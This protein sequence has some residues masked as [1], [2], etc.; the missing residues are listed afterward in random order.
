[1]LSIFKRKVEGLRELP[2][3]PESVVRIVEQID[4]EGSLASISTIIEQDQVISARVL[5]LV[6]SAFYGVGGRVSSLHHAVQMLGI[7]VLR[8][9]VLSSYFMAID[10]TGIEGLWDHASM[11]SNL[12][13]EMGKKL[14]IPHVEEVTAAALLH[15]I[16]KL[17]LREVLKDQF[18]LCI[19]EL[20]QHPAQ[21]FHQRELDFFPAGHEDAA[22]V[23][24]KRWN[25]PVLIQETAAYHHRPSLAAVY[26]KEVC[27]THLADTIVKTYGYG[28][29]GDYGVE[30]VNKV[31]LKHLALDERLLGKLV[32]E[33]AH[34]L[35]V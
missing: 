25:F 1:M 3:L 4:K 19:K 11:V 27:L 14:D 2:T 30:A 15:D 26:K 23:W 35:I 9:L 8:G 17:I 33:T 20:G 34:I 12:V 24:M 22:L 31:A 21:T 32:E 29:G 16:G 7:N 13:Y 5:K 28:F 10:D 18:D 6:N